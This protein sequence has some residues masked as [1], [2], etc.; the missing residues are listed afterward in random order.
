MIKRLEKSLIY[1]LIVIICLLSI[2]DIPKAQTNG[3][4]AY[5]PFSGD[6]DDESG[7]GH[8]GTVIGATLTAEKIK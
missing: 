1:Y 8:D 5:Y 6:A 4:V 3:L 7:N 2:S